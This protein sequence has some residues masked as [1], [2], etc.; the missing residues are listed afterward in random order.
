VSA[1][2]SA[3]TKGSTCKFVGK[4][5]SEIPANYVPWLKKA[6]AK[7]ELGPRGFSIVAAIHY[8][9]SDFGRSNEPGVKSGA[10][11]AGA[12]GPGQF[13]AETWPGYAVDANGDGKKDVYSIPDSIFATAKYMRAN[14]APG[15]WHEAIFAYNHAE[16]YVEEVLEDAKK[17]GGGNLVCESVAIGALGLLPGDPIAR[18]EYVAK[19]IEAQK[20]HY[21]W[22][23]GHGPKPGPSAG[24]GEFCG[25]GV[26]GLD[27]SGAVRWLLV[28][29]HVPDPGPITSG[30]FA[31]AFLPGPGEG[32]T[33]W[34]NAGH[35]FVTI[36]GRPWGTSHTH[37]A[38]GPAF[39]PYS[40]LG[41]AS[42][43]PL[44]F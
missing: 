32:L 1:S 24:S 39:G 34:S 43:H 26:K 31:S 7:Y 2:N 38:N 4:A 10:N 6:T 44:G 9:E 40:T 36:R 28:L 29:S 8:V 35:V 15:N 11:Y 22:G 13:L 20:I 23:G 19:W 17:F 5:S 30:T 12:E 37:F 41:F 18:V 33:I 42:S 3:G 21:C 25:P 16:W 14:G 27:C